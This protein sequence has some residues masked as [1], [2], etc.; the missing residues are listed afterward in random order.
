MVFDTMPSPVGALLITSN[1]EGLTGVSFEE[2]RHPRRRTDDRIDVADASGRAVDILRE[3]RRQLDEYF[4]GARREFD[5]PLAAGGTPF[6]Q[7]VWEQ[8]RRIP[9]GEA[10]SYL[11]L[12]RRL[13]SPRAVRAVGGANGR[14]PIPI[15]VPCHRVI[16]ADGS[17]TGFGGGIERKRWLL[18]HEGVLKGSRTGAPAESAVLSLSLD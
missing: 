12:A 8:L 17:L 5:L 10:I 7:M 6:Q 13:G 14:N 18:H 15:V 9:F 2:E 1:G 4:V 11:E 3:T 16:G